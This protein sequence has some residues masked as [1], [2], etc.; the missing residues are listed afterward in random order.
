MFPPTPPPQIY[1]L[2][3]GFSELAP[4][5]WALECIVGL[6]RLA[7]PTRGPAGTAEHPS[8]Y[9]LGGL[10]LQACAA[11]SRA[12]QPEPRPRCADALWWQCAAIDPQR[13]HLRR[14]G[15]CALDSV[16]ASGCEGLRLEALDTGAC[17]I[18]W[19]VNRAAQP[20]GPGRD[21]PTLEMRVRA[22]ERTASHWSAMVDA[23]LHRDKEGMPQVCLPQLTLRFLPASGA[24]KSGISAL[25]FEVS[26]ARQIA[27]R[28]AVHG[29]AV[30][31]DGDWILGGLRIGRHLPD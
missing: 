13:A 17:A 29:L 12:G 22:P 8:T 28:A 5:E 9:A 11:A 19:H 2:R 20:P 31:D 10:Q 18:E 21:L 27:Q 16:H 7:S 14:L 25:R 23:P 4:I 6:Q 30:Q 3:L 24:A 26:Q 15:L 1:G